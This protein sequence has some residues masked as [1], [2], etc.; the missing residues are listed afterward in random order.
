MKAPL[1]RSREAAE[2]LAVQALGFIAEEPERLTRFLNLTGLDAGEIRHAAGTPGFLG[3]VLEHMLAD[4]SLLV[5]F[6]SAAGVD[7]VEIGRARTVLSEKAQ[8]KS[9]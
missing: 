2:M 8:R 5:A 7:P 4:E 9:P 3:G 6:A 1:S